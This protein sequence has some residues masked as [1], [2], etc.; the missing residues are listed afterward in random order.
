MF[1]LKQTGLDVQM[2]KNSGK[3]KN[4]RINLRVLESEL[5]EWPFKLESIRTFIDF[6]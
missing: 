2:R 6:I 3:T 5:N 4:V 1:P